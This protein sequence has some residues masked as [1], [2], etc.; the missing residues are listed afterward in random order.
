M[1]LLTSYVQVFVV[2]QY[3]VRFQGILLPT[4]ATTCVCKAIFSDKTLY[5]DI[6]VKTNKRKDTRIVYDTMFMKHFTRKVIHFIG[7]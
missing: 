7:I 3:R 6:E 4:Q 1:K 2:N 5:T